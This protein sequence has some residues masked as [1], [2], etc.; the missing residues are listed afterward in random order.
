MSKTKTKAIYPND[1]KRYRKR[2]NLKIIDIARLM[3]LESPARISH[4]EKGRKLPSLNNALKLSVILNCP[5][6]AL[7]FNHVQA[8]RKDISQKRKSN[9]AI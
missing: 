2:L 7:F 5:V 8:I 9:K 4:W 3:D 1:L 6:I